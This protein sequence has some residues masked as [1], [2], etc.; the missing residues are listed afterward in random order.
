MLRNTSCFEFDFSR[1]RIAVFDAEA[2]G[3]ER[4]D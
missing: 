2:G 4:G 3:E 1:K